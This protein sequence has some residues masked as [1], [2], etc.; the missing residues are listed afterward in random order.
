M[1]KNWHKTF[2]KSEI[3]NEEAKDAAK[4]AEDVARS[5]QEKKLETKLFDGV[6]KVGEKV[7]KPVQGLFERIWGFVKKVLL[8]DIVRRLFN[9]R[10][11]LK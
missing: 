5:N 3:D 2:L 9:C 11:E 7:L 1:E 6:K 8:A 10:I 4:D